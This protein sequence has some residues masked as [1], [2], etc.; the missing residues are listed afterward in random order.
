[1]TKQPYRKRHLFPR[2]I[3]EVVKNAT[4]PLMDKQ[5]KLYG[6]L[7]RDWTVIVGEQRALHTRP[8]RLQWPTHEAS[9]AILHLQVR[10]SMAPEITYE[11]QQMIEQCARYFGYRAIE[12]MVLHPSH[13]F[14][15]IEEKKAPPAAA[16]TPRDMNDILHRL[17]QRI[18]GDDKRE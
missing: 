1:M 17:R 8:Q 12:R 4:K 16:P 10:A 5:G 18:A 2:T 13:E 11:T 14:A 15:T 7:L 3:D 6:A 9:G